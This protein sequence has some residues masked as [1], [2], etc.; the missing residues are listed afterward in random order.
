MT[1]QTAV[2][3]WAAI[4]CLG[5]AVFTILAIPA[6]NHAIRGLFTARRLAASQLARTRAPPAERRQR[7]ARF[8]QPRTR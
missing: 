6:F 1:A 7:D 4:S 8:K 3:L 5:L 2:F